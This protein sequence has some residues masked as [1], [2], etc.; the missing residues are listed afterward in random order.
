MR[1]A[2]ISTAMWLLWAAEVTAQGEASRFPPGTSAILVDSA[3]SVLRQCTRQAPRGIVEFWQP[4]DSL[5][6]ALEGPLLALLG[7]VLPRARVGDHPTRALGPREYYR[8][9]V[10][11]IRHGRPL[12]YVNAFPKPDSLSESIAGKDYWRTIPVD[13]CDGGAFFFGVVYDVGTRT[14]ESIDF[15]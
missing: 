1:I 9:Y 15:Q 11:I 12:I 2:A 7:Q 3:A 6:R 4:T 8:Q 14:F 13:V 5:V 10:G